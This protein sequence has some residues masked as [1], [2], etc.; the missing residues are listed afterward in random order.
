MRTW[1]VI[2]SLTA[3]VFLPCAHAMDLWQVWQLA[4]TNDPAFRQAQSTVKAAQ[5]DKPA[6]WAQLFP[7]INLT[8]SRTWTNSD[9]SGLRFFGGTQ[10]IPLEST[11]ND[12]QDQWGAQLSQPIFNWQ[13]IKA[14]GG[15][16]ISVAQA[17]AQYR[18][19]VQGLILT[20]AQAYFGV[21]QAKD[22]LD[23]DL[24][25][26]LALE[27]QFQEV[28]QQYK[29][30]LVAITGVKQA[31]AGYDQAKAQVIASRQS[32]AQAQE[33]LRAIIG[34]VPSALSAPKANL[35]L[36]PPKPDSA[37]AWVHRGLQDNPNLVA[38]R[39]GF[40]L[41][42]NQVSQTQA[43]YLPQINLLLSHTRQSLLGNSSY[44]SPTGAFQSPDQSSGSTNEIALDFSWNIF[45][46]GATRA[47]TRKAEFQADA[48]S[49]A[50]AT[51][52]RT[53]VQDVRN[54]FLGVLSGIAQ[55]QATRQSVVA[56]HVALQAT[57][58]G[59]KVGTQTVLDVLNARNTYLTAEKSFYS[60]RYSYLLATLQLEQAA[61]SLTPG[62]LKALNGLLSKAILPAQSATR[63]P[64]EASLSM[65]SP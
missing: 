64:A 46:G 20:V 45:S 18:A 59:L 27:K 41:A 60:A 22:N 43:G 44:S 7:S 55:V 16:D 50:S 23:A 58:A 52:H 35:P 61:G 36:N 10:S 26:Q 15:A 28:T 13:L 32:L 56:A 24:A 8:A 19:T 53:V 30:G 42:Q 4:R 21:L 57:Q 47:A 37:T 65:S 14:V 33:A 5:E 9:S 40:K 54:A 11:S 63:T 51:E 29:V 31:Q 39:L 34:R 38:S 6:A 12:R 1:P 48:A 2:V 62:A 17:E 25:N 3:L 49:A